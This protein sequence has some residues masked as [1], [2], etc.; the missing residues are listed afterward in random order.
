MAQAAFDPT[1]DS[2]APG[3]PIPKGMPSADQPTGAVTGGAATATKEL[4]GLQREKVAAD[5][6]LYGD[7]THSADEA[8]SLARHA[9]E[10]ESASLNDP[11]LKPW[12][13]AKEQA[14]HQT[15]PIQAF[16]SLG[17]VFGIIASSFTNAPF[18]NSLNASAAA[19]N[20][21]KKGD[22]QGYEDA[23][24]AWED[25]YNLALKRHE[26]QH[27][28]YAD[29]VTLLRTNMAAG[30]A[31]LRVLAAK[32]GDKQTLA[33]LDAG[34]SKDVIELQAARQ[35]TATQLAETYPK[36]LAWN[37]EKTF[38]S[39]KTHDYERQGL[40]KQKAEIKAYQDWQEEQAKF[41]REASPFA[42]RVTSATT[43][44]EFIAQRMQEIR[45]SGRVPTSKDMLEA[46]KEWTK[47]TTKGLDVRQRA[48]DIKAESDAERGRHNRAVEEIQSHKGDTSAA[49]AK[50]RERHDK[51]MEEI[52]GRTHN[53]ATNLTSDRQIAAD[54]ADI[55][56][57]YKVDNPDATPQEIADYRAKQTRR[58]KQEAT[59]ITSNRA[60]QIRGKLGQVD[61]AE[62]LISN[63]EN[64]LKKHDAITG[65]GGKVT[66][67]MEIM[68]NIFGGNATDRVQFERWVE[69]LQMIAP[70][71]LL[72]SRGRPLS[73]EAGATYTIIAGLRM[74]DTLANTAR[75]YYELRKVL[76]GIKGRLHGR[77][78][79]KVD[80]TDTEK[81]PAPQ[82]DWWKSSPRVH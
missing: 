12:D 61:Q 56:N 14:A 22:R 81:P 53:A 55:V 15:D 13:E 19:I 44:A 45:D 18:T 34:Y 11:A 49:M 30:E 36:I 70:R 5:E 78:D 16:G 37:A 59:P 47:V 62:E 40:D 38:V 28:Q 4:A 26:M 25:N 71:I 74:G 3:E 51:A 65:L 67:P 60:D 75:A 54:V 20:A 46:Q 29:A 73:H 7:I 24:K 79:N 6:K 43:Q 39:D 52:Y 66:R 58:L 21:I 2:Y 42:G 57:R 41:K 23:R 68:Q 76:D 33:L 50:E 77:L 9:Y 27:Q 35:R 69:E 17:S 48:L 72:D 80:S 32:F 10:Q 82:G 64:M 8:M 1:K 31:K 63:I